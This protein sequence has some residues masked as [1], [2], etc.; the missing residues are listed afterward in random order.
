MQ[1]QS[2]TTLLCEI[3][4]PINSAITSL[5][6]VQKCQHPICFDDRHLIASCY[7]VSKQAL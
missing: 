6:E 3:L 7:D 2:G 4:D 5:I 1:L